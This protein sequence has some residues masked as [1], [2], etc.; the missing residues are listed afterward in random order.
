MKTFSSNK[1]PFSQRELD[2]SIK[3][4]QSVIPCHVLCLKSLCIVKYNYVCET[5][6]KTSIT[7]C[8]RSLKYIQDNL[9]RPC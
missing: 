4:A 5:K 3:A 7:Y 8:D 9:F 6:V 2:E 1:L